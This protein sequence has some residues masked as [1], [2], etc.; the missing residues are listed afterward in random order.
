MSSSQQPYNLMIHIKGAKEHNL[1][2][3]C[4]SIP[5]NKMTVITGVS[6]SGKSSLAF[7]TIYAEGQRRYMESLSSYA[8]QFLD[9]L[10]KPEVDSIEGLSAAIAIEQKS[11]F[12]N[13]RSTVGTSTEIYDYLRLLFAK[14][15]ELTCPEGHGKIQSIG[16]DTIFEKISHLPPTS[17][18]QIFAPIERG[19]KGQFQK[20]T[21]GF[22]KKGYSHVRIDGKIYKTSENIKL[23]K[24]KKHDFDILIDQILLEEKYHA[25]ILSSI[26]RALHESNGQIIVAHLDTHNEIYFN[27][28]L[29]CPTCHYTFPQIESRFFSFNSPYGACPECQG[30][31]QKKSID[32]N[33]L[34]PNPNLSLSDGA[35]LPWTSTTYLEILSSLSQHFD[36]NM[37]TPFKDLPEKVKTLLLYGTKEEVQYTYSRGSQKYE[38]EESFEGVIPHLERQFLETFSERK[39][40]NIERFFNFVSCPLCN[41]I[42][43]KKES[44]FITINGLAIS[45]FCSLPISE[46]ARVIAAWKFDPQKAKIGTKVKAEIEERL[47][48]LE[49]VGLGYL[50]LDRSTSTLSTGEAQRIKLASQLGSHLTGVLYVLDEP[51]IGLH[52]RDHHKLLNS[53]FKLREM[54]NTLIVVEHDEDTIL[55]SDHII[56]MGPGAGT[57]GGSITAE[58]TPQEIKENPQSLTGLYLS[59]KKQVFPEEKKT[60]HKTSKKITLKNVRSRNLKNISIDFPLGK[61]ICI[62]GVSGSGKSSLIMDTLLPLLNHHLYKSKLPQ[63]CVAEEISGMNHIDKVIHVDQSPIGK[64]PR[65]NPATYTGI[66]APLRDF[67]AELPLS[68]MRGFKAGRFSFNVPGGRCELCEGSGLLK[69]EMHFLPNVY[70]TCSKC[71]G[72]RYNQETLQATYKGKNIAEI[73]DLTI[74]EGSEFFENIP[75]IKS[76]LDVLLDVGL[77]YIHLGQQAPTLSG[78]EAQRI[79]LAK[80]LSKRSTGSTFYILDEPT[81]G[82]HFD[83]IHKLLNVLRKLVNQ[84]NTVVVIEHQLDIIAHSDHIIDIGPE[85]G[86]AGGKIVATGTPQE[87][88]AHPNSYTGQF[89]KKKLLL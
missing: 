8:R 36:F 71:E 88:A 30:I 83:D 76:K 20:E 4:V 77:G 51:S 86:E 55:S 5:R 70:V 79:K 64:T 38:F 13:P 22:E 80:E 19:R 68:K 43:L 3:V 66:F 67:Y 45:D 63:Y 44:R 85:G 41:G 32:L 61:M 16:E 49:N 81:T 87:I 34:I 23:D 9:Q 24:N 60:K 6:G 10:K 48:F 12:K 2:N 73:L 33:L 82:L 1:K 35:L 21:E 39:R 84:G 14:L 37:K 69:I 56:D 58:G 65:S 15:G 46:A 47:S 50:T 59:G 89:L 54:G 57:G 74:S 72:K 17:K 26:K 78:G 27:T 75:A 31:G 52:P 25:R 28:K 18:L 29:S 7:D 11:L 42:R 40:E 62:T 53:L